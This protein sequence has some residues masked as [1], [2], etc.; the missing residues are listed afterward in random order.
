MVVARGFGVRGVPTTVIV[1]NKGMINARVLGHLDFDGPAL[2]SY[3]RA[4]AK[5]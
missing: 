2:R 3:V 4:L 1:D 5:K